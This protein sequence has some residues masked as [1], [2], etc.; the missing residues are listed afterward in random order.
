MLGPVAAAPTHE[1][2]VDVRF[3]FRPEVP[4]V[5]VLSNGDPQLAM[6]GSEHVGHSNDRGWSTELWRVGMGGRGDGDGPG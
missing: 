4:V 5:L 6:E 3:R 1:G 2:I